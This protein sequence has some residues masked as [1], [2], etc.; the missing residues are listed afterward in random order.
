MRS[1]PRPMGFLVRRKRP[2]GSTTVVICSKSPELLRKCL[3]SVH[4]TA[5]RAVSQIVVIAHED[6][7]ATPGSA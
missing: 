5:D 1:R 4:A 3:S 7:G 6:S 2:S